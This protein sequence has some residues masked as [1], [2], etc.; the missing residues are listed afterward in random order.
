MHKQKTYAKNRLT[1]NIVCAKKSQF[2]W[3]EAN[4]SLTNIDQIV[5]N[6]V[7]AY[8]IAISQ[9]FEKCTPF[10]EKIYFLYKINKNTRTCCSQFAKNTRYCIMVIEIVTI[11]FVWFEKILLK[12]R[13]EKGRMKII[14]RSGEEQQLDRKS[15]V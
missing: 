6:L 14:K 15:V 12:A 2:Q 5:N 3:V 7:T 13:K 8:F 10:F 4:F 9:F 11:L 1:Q